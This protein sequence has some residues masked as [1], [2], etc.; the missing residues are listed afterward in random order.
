MI[1]KIISIMLVVGAII[2]FAIPQYS[3]YRLK[4]KLKRQMSS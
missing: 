1:R 2:M 4:E 3:K